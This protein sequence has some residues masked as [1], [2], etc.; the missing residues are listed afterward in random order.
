MPRLHKHFNVKR[1]FK[2]TVMKRIFI[3]PLFLFA[4]NLF[5]QTPERDLYQVTKP[6]KKIYAD[7]RKNFIVVF[8]M[9][10]YLD[11][12][13]IGSSIKKID[14]L[15]LQPGNA[16]IGKE[17]KIETVNNRLY[18]RSLTGKTKGYELGIVENK[19]LA[20][21][22]LN[23]AYFLDSY[24]AMS[25]RLNKKYQLNHFDFRNGFYSWEQIAEKN[26]NYLEFRIIVDNLIKKT[27]DR[28]AK[29]QDQLVSR[30]KYLIDNVDKLTYT[31]FKDSI[32]NIPAEF[33]YQSS[34]Y[35]TV[36]SEVS[37][38][39]QEYV[40]ALYKDFPENRIL[41]E[42]AV[43]KNKPLLQKLRAIQKSENNLAKKR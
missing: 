24:F 27:E 28:V 37:K 8:D 42:F 43:E 15:Y 32:S 35:K 21:Q 16:Y 31:E 9:G 17:F 29:Q 40:L 38:T 22:D 33:A 1:D 39:K 26:I 4:G 10:K 41:I 23:N 19:K 36:V 14:T 6:F 20:L 34:Y 25:H 12:A 3:L 7:N 30:T 11:K 5:G 2:E 13:G 18:I